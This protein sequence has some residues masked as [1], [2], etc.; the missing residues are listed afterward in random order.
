MLQEAVIVAYGR[1]AV[2]RAKKG[3]LANV[4]PVDWAAET[5][6]GVLAQVPQLKPEWISDLILGCAMPVKTLNLNVARQVIQRAQLPDSIC[7]QT[8]NR[9]CSSGLQAIATCANAIM[10]GQEEEIGRAHV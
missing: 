10:C 5:L 9:Y 2:C 1:S 6:K 3:A 7:A 8:I 4:H